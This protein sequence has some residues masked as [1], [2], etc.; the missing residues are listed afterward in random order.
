M[1]RSARLVLPAHPHYVFHQGN[2]RQT[3]FYDDEDRMFYLD[4]LEKA[5]RQYQ[6][7]IHAYVLL[8]N[9]VHLL[10]TPSDG[11]GLARMMQWM[12]RCYV[13][14]FNRRYDHTGTLWEGRFRTS[15]IEAELWLMK[16]CRFIEMRPVMT[17][18]VE[19][20]EE[21]RW[22]S[23]GH[24]AGTG[25]SPVI[26]DSVF[27][28]NLGNT[29][30]ARESAYLAFL[31]E[32]SQDEDAYLE[33]VLTKGWPLGSRPFIAQLEK[34]VGKPFRMGRRGRPARKSA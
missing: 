24:H 33:Q 30:F 9:S 4:C 27:Y 32:F 31:Q 3:V 12:G 20:A 1:A 25:H 5:S 17:G 26:R 16:C 11:E 23:Y 14:C 29:P 8:E 34:R 28:W 2:N 10:A 15:V 18:L 19:R 21:Y 7:D 22:S 13:P 6:V